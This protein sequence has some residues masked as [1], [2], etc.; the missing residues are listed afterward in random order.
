MATGRDT[1]GRRLVAT[2]LGR[3]NATGSG[4]RVSER[5]HRGNRAFVA[6]GCGQSSV[7]V[8]VYQDATT[9]LA[10][11]N[12]S[13]YGQEYSFRVPPAAMAPGATIDF[14][15]YLTNTW[16]CDTGGLIAIVDRVSP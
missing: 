12:I 16:S 5:P 10:Q 6:T 11:G 9:A 3:A 7:N 15:G 2:A 1:G 8:A 4:M 13:A 14:T